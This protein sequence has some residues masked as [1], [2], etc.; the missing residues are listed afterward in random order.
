MKGDVVL[1]P[2]STDQENLSY[3]GDEVERL[4]TPVKPMYDK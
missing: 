4:S 2:S 3:E 1:P